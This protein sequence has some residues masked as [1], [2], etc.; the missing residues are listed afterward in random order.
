MPKKFP[1]H[2]H[3]TPGDPEFSSSSGWASSGRSLLSLFQ[4]HGST[5]FHI[6]SRNRNHESRNGF[7]QEMLAWENGYK[8]IPRLNLIVS[9]E[10]WIHQETSRNIKEHPTTPFMNSTPVTW[11][12]SA[13]NAFSQSFNDSFQLATWT[14]TIHSWHSQATWAPTY[15][16]ISREGWMYDGGVL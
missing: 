8:E 15:I 14:R 7:S 11:W 5:Q 16:A 3:P 10:I 1:S 9:L 12:S 13:A 6:H 2:T 4:L